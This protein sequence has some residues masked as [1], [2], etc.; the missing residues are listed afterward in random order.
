MKHL[1]FLLLLIVAGRTGSSQQLNT[2]SFSE[3]APVLHNPATTGSSRHAFLGSSFKTQWS[4]MPGKPQTALLYGQAFLPAARLGLGGYLY[5]DVTGPTA[6]T[7]LQMAYAY[8]IPFKEGQSLSFGLEARLQQL[9]F[10]REKLQA[11]LGGADPVAMGLRNRLK[12]DGGFGIAYTSP[13]LQ[14]GASVSQLV[15]TKYQLYE[16]IGNTTEQSK[17]YRHWYLH[18]AYTFLSD[19]ETKIIPNLLLIYLP[20]APLEMQ[21][22]V[23]VEH[24][25]LFFYSLGWRR[26]QG[27]MLSAGVKPTEKLTIGY[28]FDLYASP[29]SLYE[30]GSSGHE[31]LLQYQF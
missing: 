15:Q 4:S 3:L 13:T 30:S 18:G 8:H 1:A 9:S 31:L 6:R 27:W 16:M 10:D 28:A 25:H 21:S 24:N 7:G 29:V 20:N 19:D 17:L 5:H 22:S 14:V 2:S 23:K 26:N 11:E 12:A